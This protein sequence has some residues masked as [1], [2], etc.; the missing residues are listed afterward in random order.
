MKLAATAF[1]IAAILTVSTVQGRE[2]KD[3]TGSYTV[4][5]DLVSCNE[6]LVQLKRPD[7]SVISVPL[8][9]LSAHDREYAT[10]LS[11]Q[12]PTTR[13]LTLAELVSAIEPAVVRIN[14]ITGL[15]SGFVVK[16]SGIVITNFHVVEG[17]GAATVSFKDGRSVK[18]AGY[19]G[20]NIEKDIAILK[21]EDAAGPLPFLRLRIQRTTPSLSPAPNGEGP[22]GGFLGS[23]RR[24]TAWS[25]PR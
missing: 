16:P 18:V 17:S 3:V 20:V 13:E 7:G 6:G 15:G 1:W 9:Q 22:R 4:E 8:E 14:T 21:L 12:P 5:A 11:G 24:P 2:W 23:S 25:R 19:L 10:L